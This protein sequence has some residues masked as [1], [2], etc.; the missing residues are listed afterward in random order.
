VGLRQLSPARRDRQLWE[1][2]PFDINVRGRYFPFDLSE[3]TLSGRSFASTLV[4]GVL[5]AAMNCVSTRADN[6]A[7]VV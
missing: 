4:A 6:A 5:H 3:Q 1:L 2:L 7:S